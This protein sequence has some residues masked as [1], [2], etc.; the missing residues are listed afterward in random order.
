[1]HECPDCGQP[2]AEFEDEPCQNC[3][4]HASVLGPEDDTY[5]SNY[6]DC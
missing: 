1:M 4:E 5:D 6:E 3:A 2:T